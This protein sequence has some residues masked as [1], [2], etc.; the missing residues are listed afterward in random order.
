[1]KVTQYQRRPQK[2]QMSIE[3]VFAAVRE[4]MPVDIV[5]RA[6]VSRFVSRGILR[7][8]YNMIEARFHQ[9][10]VNHITGDVHF[11]AL[12]LEKRRTVLTILDSVSLERLQGLRREILRWLWYVLPI[13]RS[14][15]VTAISESSKNELLRHVRCDPSKIRVIPVCI[16]GD[17]GAEPKEFNAVRPRILQVGAA[18]NK[19]VRR[20]AE[21]LAGIPCEWVIVGA[22]DPD[23]EKRFRELG[24]NYRALG[25]LDAAGVH[26]A[27][28]SC[29][30]LVFASTYEGFGLPIVE[31]NA[32]GR[33]VVTSNILSMP[34]VAGDAAC[35]VDPFDAASIRAGVLRVLNE[36]EYRAGLVANG[37]R[38]AGRFSAENVARQYAAIY[39]EIAG[40]ETERGR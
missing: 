23:D 29:D 13:A 8:A 10:D 7:R 16:P 3:R 25:I 40:S 14:A 34:E 30:L 11:L 9:A 17:F 24:L 35:L 15:A 12:L 21:A 28:R 4:K 31:A 26:D 22:V 5:C 39:R 27:Y 1:M 33:P 38:N 37:F 36:P 19:N 20:V 18:A 32:V 2:G 6:F